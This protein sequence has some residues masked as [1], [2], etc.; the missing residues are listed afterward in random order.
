MLL[1][2][3]YYYGISTVLHLYCPKLYSSIITTS[4]AITI[5][6]CI[7]KCT[8]L[9]VK[10]IIRVSLSGD[11]SPYSVF[12]Y[13]R[14]Y[15][16]FRD[17]V[18]EGDR[19]QIPA[20]CRGLFFIASKANCHIGDTLFPGSVP[21][22]LLLEWCCIWT[23]NDP[24]HPS[25]AKAEADLR[26]AK[27]KLQPSRLAYLWAFS[28]WKDARTRRAAATVGEGASGFG[29]ESPRPGAKPLTTST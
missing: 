10:L 16:V 27:T 28:A 15:N 12:I 1:L 29:A 2:Q 19:L 6:S 4:I 3:Y 14:W 23:L 25:G 11:I 22:S 17:Q 7:S 9:C 13:F 18:F 26:I 20:N 5:L 8:L 24:P 21:A